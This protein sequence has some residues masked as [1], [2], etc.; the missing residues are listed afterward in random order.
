MFK[1]ISKKMA[2]LI[3]SFNYTSAHKSQNGEFY[4]GGLNGITQFSIENLSE[5]KVLPALNFTQLEVFNQQWDTLTQINRLSEKAVVLSPYDINLKVDWSV[6]DYFSKDNYN[7][8][9]M[10]KGFENQ[11]FYQ[12][13]S[14]NILYNQLPAGE[15]TLKV[16]AVDIKGN[17]SKAGI[18][19]PIIVNQIFYKTWWFITLAILGIA[20]MVYSFFSIDFSRLWPWK[21]SAPKSQAICTTMWGR[22]LQAWRCRPKCWRCRQRLKQTNIN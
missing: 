19:I 9:T 10:M 12:G 18:E 7:Y 16:K 21:D 22:C 17:K 5:K 20:A 11:W 4:F 1:I 8:Y 13:N 14:S 6:P 15:Y 2:F 3:M